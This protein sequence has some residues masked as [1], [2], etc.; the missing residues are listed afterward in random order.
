MTDIDK[1]TKAAIES[2]WGVRKLSYLKKL[3]IRLMVI[4]ALDA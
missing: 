3:Q 4:A 1:A 2:Y